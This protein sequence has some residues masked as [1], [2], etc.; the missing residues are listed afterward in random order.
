MPGFGV[1]GFWGFWVE[2]SGQFARLRMVGFRGWGPRLS[3][4][5]LGLGDRIRGK[6][7]DIDP[8]NKVPV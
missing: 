2:G 5:G 8:L 7:G 6:F 3:G 4:F 1:L